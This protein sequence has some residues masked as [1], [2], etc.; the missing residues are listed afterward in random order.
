MIGTR[1]GFLL[2]YKIVPTRRAGEIRLEPTIQR[3]NKG[4]SKKAILQVE[5]CSEFQILICL[6]DSLVSVH[7]LDDYSTPVIKTDFL[8]SKCRGALMFVTNVAKFEGVGGE[9]VSVLRL[10]V[11]L[12]RRL[13]IFYWKKD[14]FYELGPDLVVPD[15]P[16][17]IAWV[18]ESLCVGFR[19]EYILLKVPK[20]EQKALIALGVRNT[21]PLASAINSAKLLSL[22]Q[23]DKS[24]ILNGEGDPILDYDIPWADFPQTI[25][26]DMPYLLCLLPTSDSRRTSTNPVIEIQTMEPRFPVQKIMDN[27]YGKIKQMVKCCNRKGL[28][29]FATSQD[30]FA[31]L[32]VSQQ[33]QITLLLRENQFELAKQLANRHAR[34]RKSSSISNTSS[35]PSLSKRDSNQSLPS[36]C[37]S[38][39]SAANPSSQEDTIKK[40][41]HLHAFHLF[42]KKDFKES[43]NLFAKLDTDPSLVIGLFPNLVPE[44]TRSKFEYPSPPPVL[45]DMDL[46]NGL[47]AL[48]DYLLPVRRKL[49]PDN[50]EDQTVDNERS[51]QQLRQ[52]V[53]TTLLKCYL[54]T[55]DGLV[56]SLVN[57]PDN[58]CHVEETE[59]ALIQFKK[60]NEL[61][62][63]YRSK[64]LHRK[65]LEMLT[66][67]SREEKRKVSVAS[68]AKS[69]DSNQGNSR[70][71]T[72]PVTLTMH[73]RVVNYLQHLP[74]SHLS[75][76]FEY[77]EW[78][79]REY[80]ED[81]L[82]I[83][84]ED[85]GS[86]TEL[87]PRDKVIEFLERVNSSL[88]CQ[89][90]EHVIDVWNDQTPAFHNLLIK[91]YREKVNSLL[92]EYISS[93]PKGHTPNQPGQEP[94]ELGIVRSKLL[95]FLKKS[96]SYSTDV[97]PSHFLRDGLHHERA[98][99]MGRIGNHR[100]ALSIYIN[101]LKDPK[102]AEQYCN[103]VFQETGN[104]EVSL[105]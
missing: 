96:K 26:D 66:A 36:I 102:E 76:L 104:K 89:Y 8:T 62:V 94:G 87:L 88:V 48:S 17:S 105:G 84:I 20:G 78:V 73:E 79:I 90:L 29:Y 12:K 103:R 52:I 22:V 33:Q 27:G 53:D 80:P 55:S 38:P 50:K 70:S 57:L 37:D 15:T 25:V 14:N 56:A 69:R 43:M 45:E 39:D 91:N 99:V 54:H 1:Q 42:C 64:G 93:L 28:H 24:Y 5:A 21:E 4:F 75:L 23:D 46:K 10:C 41:D 11:A 9:S 101:Y 3:S 16:R 32:A 13:L 58:N 51:R 34:N 95:S 68:M 74:P 86:E 83:F 31:L 72:P 97:L 65:A 44:K 47:K 61:I 30:I 18:G 49:A 40:I 92:K 81:G 7:K 2:L 71:P 60:F 19:T 82:K 59:E 63:F 85:F 98:L 35:M 6:S 67:Q 100:E 77:S